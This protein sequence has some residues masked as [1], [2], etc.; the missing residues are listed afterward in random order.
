M[1]EILID[2]DAEI[3]ALVQ[4]LGSV[5]TAAADPE[6]QEAAAQAV[7]DRLLSY[8]LLDQSQ[9]LGAELQDIGTA[10]LVVALPRVERKILVETTE[11]LEI[12]AATGR[13]THVL[14][15]GCD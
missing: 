14:D 15:E 12:D 7:L 9:A 2:Q 13:V 1:R 10:V 6:Q 3:A 8:G 4:V 11:W 5:E